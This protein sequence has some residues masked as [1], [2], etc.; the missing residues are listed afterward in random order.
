MEGIKRLSDYKALS[1]MRNSETQN[2]PVYAVRFETKVNKAGK[3]QVC[4]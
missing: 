3:E 1:E 4:E 2:R